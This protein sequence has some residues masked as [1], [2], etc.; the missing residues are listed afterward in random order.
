MFIQVYVV[1]RR[2]RGKK[3][4][5]ALRWRQP[6]LDD[7][8]CPVYDDEGQVVYRTRTESAKTSDKVT[9]KQC[10]EKK[11]RE[12]N[13]LD[14]PE[15]PEQ[16]ITLDELAD[17]DAQWLENRLR[18]KGTIY[19]T[20]LA[21]RHLQEIIGKG[22]PVDAAGIG[23]REVERFIAKRRSD[24]G[25]CAVNRELGNLRAAYNRAV[26]VHKILTENPFAKVEKLPVDP[27]EINP[28]TA[29]E[30]GKLLAA[31]AGDLELDTFVRIALDTG[32]RAG[33][34]AHLRWEDLQLDEGLGLIRCAADWRS[35]TRRN[36]VIAFTPDTIER[37]RRWRLQRAFKAYVFYDEDEKER[38]TYRRMRA[39]FG[40]AVTNAGITRRTLH[41]LRR[42]VG[43]LLAER[44]INQRVAAEILGHSDPRT[45]AKYYQAVRPE[46]IKRTVLNLRR[47]GTD[48]K[49]SE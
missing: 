46:T 44:N 31:C 36:R 34:I 47:T 15:E 37:L 41:D 2:R 40:E 33:E 16:H 49:P 35:K 6:V 9:A 45:T 43:T 14:Q 26:E 48:D 19:L 32:C 21:I 39:K 29:E 23:P 27:K 8:G 25:P 12:L 11:Y 24:V 7:E 38:E 5:Y 42:T 30:E 4:H 20:R 18:S 10:A 17:I 3:K 28:L 22:K 1:A 13:G